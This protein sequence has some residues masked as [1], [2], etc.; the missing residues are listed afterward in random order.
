MQGTIDRSQT[1]RVINSL[2]YDNQ[3]ISAAGAADMRLF[4]LTITLA[5]NTFGR[6]GA[7]GQD[8]VVFFRSNLAAENNI[9]SGYQTS[10]LE[11]QTAMGITLSEDYNL[12]FNAPLGATLPAGAHNLTGDP[13]FAD[14]ANNNFQPRISSPAIDSGDKS[15]LPADILTDLGNLFR[16]IDVPGVLNTGAGTPPVDRGAYEFPA[17]RVYIPLVSR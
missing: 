9:W 8:S 3:R 11:G 7:A 2:F 17:A 1:L 16:F 4:D 14:P 13:Q 12:L 5:N 6:P 10:L 15:I